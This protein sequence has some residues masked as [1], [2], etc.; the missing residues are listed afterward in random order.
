MDIFLSY[1]AA[2]FGGSVLRLNPGAWK[3]P[4]PWVNKSARAG[5]LTCFCGNQNGYF[6]VSA[7]AASKAG[8]KRSS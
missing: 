1:L 7:R 3:L 2:S 6:S 5:V 4:S 8:F